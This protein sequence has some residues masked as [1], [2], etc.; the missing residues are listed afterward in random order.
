MIS[1][2]LRCTAFSGSDRIATGELRHVAL[3]AKQAYDAYPERPLRVFDDAEA[4]L[5][6]LPLHLSP[7]DL[8][9]W[10]AQPRRE[11]DAASPRL[12]RP[13]RPKLGVVAREVTLLPAQWEWLAA[14]PGGAS[15]ALRR[16]VD[17]ARAVSAAQD[18]RRAAQ[19]AAYRFMQA[20]ADGLTDV[21]AAA[22]ALFAAEYH[23]FQAAIAGWPEDVREHAEW[24]ASDA[25]GI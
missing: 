17:A 12:R 9:A 5:L 11:G 4:R 2:S 19:E 22:R 21:E 7:A 1:P 10:L 3:K 24:L 15:L 14:Q 6:E 20:M 18:R 23:P 8:L 13:G 16:L 25:F